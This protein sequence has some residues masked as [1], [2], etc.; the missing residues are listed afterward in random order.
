MKGLTKNQTELLL[1]VRAGGPDGDLD[2]DQLLDQLSWAPSKESAQFTIRA[3]VAK[4]VLQK[5]PELQFRRSRKRICYRVTP[6][7]LLA[8][9]PRAPLAAMPERSKPLV[10]EKPPEAVSEGLPEAEDF[11]LPGL[12][13]VEEG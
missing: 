13:E 10:A 7:G 3:L 5:L 6:E 4:G 12:V 8:L 1:A 9:D 2:F 11:F